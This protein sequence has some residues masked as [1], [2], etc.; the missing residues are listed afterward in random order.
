M[1]ESFTAKHFAIHEFVP[2][3]VYED[4]GE[5]AWQLIDHRLVLNCDSLKEQLEKIYGKRIPVTINNW[6]WDGDR[7]ASGLRIPGQKNYKPY[8]QH[9]FG[10]AQDS[11][12]EVP[13]QEIRDHIKAKRIL[14][15]HSATFEE[16]VS[17]LHMDVRS[18]INGHTYFFNI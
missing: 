12:C 10:R 15:P 13:A 4:R 2:Q 14:L 8:S 18:M 5:K 9:S 16:G 3:S 17:W 6:F 7:D 1:I 11:I